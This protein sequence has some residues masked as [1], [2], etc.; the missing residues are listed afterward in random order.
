MV[1]I[2]REIIEQLFDK[3]DSDQDGRVSFDEFLDGLFQ[4]DS[5]VYDTASDTHNSDNGVNLM[6]L[7]QECTHIP[8]ASQPNISSLTQSQCNR[9]NDLEPNSHENNNN[10]N[11]LQPHKTSF[12][13]NMPSAYL[14]TLDPDRTG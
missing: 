2:N 3:L 5:A 13:D 14:S 12:F 8:S 7:P 11:L 4:H 9:M 10:N 6:Q 1:D